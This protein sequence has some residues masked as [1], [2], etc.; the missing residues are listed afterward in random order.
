MGDGVLCF[1]GWPQAHEDEAER[2]VRA[3]LAIMQAMASMKA[4]DGEAL[5][6]RAGIATG[7][8]V[9]GDL[10]GEGAAQEE[11]VVGEAPNLAA[12]LQALAGPGQIVLSGATRRLLGDLFDLTDLGS[13]DLKGIAG[14]VEA[15]AVVGERAL[16]SRFE[17]R[18]PTLLSPLVGRDQEL[19]LILERWRQA[20]AGEGQVVLLSG[21]AG[22]GKSRIAQ[23]V[24]DTLDAE[25]HV[26]L[27]YQCSPYH[28]DSALYPTIQQ[29]TR[30]AGILHDDGPDTRLDKLE[31]LLSQGSED[32]RGVTPFIAALLGIEYE[33][34]YGEL[35]LGPQQQRSRTL[36]ILVDQLIG[37]AGK[38]PVLFC[39]EDLH[40]VDPTTLEL[41]ELA[42]D[43]MVEAPVLLLMTARPTFDH[44]VGGHPIVTRLALNRLG[45]SQIVAIAERITGGK[46]LPIDLLEEIAS[47]T[48]GVPLFVEE[49]TKTVLES[50]Q[51]RETETAFELDAP[52]ERL[53]IP[54]TLHD[55]LMARL[56][57]LQ[58]VKE[59]AQIAACIG[60]EFG[61]GL[62]EAA[63][64]LS[65][66]K[67]QEA[68]DRLIAAELIF[69]RGRPPEAFYIF[70]HALVRDAA[71][72]SLLKSK[73][74]TIH[75]RLLKVLEEEHVGEA[76]PEV[77]AQHAAEAGLDEK[78][79]DLWET[80]GQA[81]VA[82]PAYR[83]A[84]NHFSLAIARIGDQVESRHWQERE[85][86]LQVKLGQAL[87]AC[88]G[89]QAA[90][91]EQAFERA[92]IL[93]EALG[94][95]ALRFPA[96]YGQW[97]VSVLR[98]STSGY[99]KKAKDFYRLASAQEDPAPKIVAHRLL[100]VSRLM[101]GQLAEAR[102][103]FE[104]GLTYHCPGQ[105]HALAQSF[106]Q[107]PET[108]I[109][110]GLGWSLRLLGYPDQADHQAA[111][112]VR[113]AAALGHMN[114]LIYAHSWATFVALAIGD[115]RPALESFQATK[116]LT[117]Q[118]DLR[119][120]QMIS[121]TVDGIRRMDEG[122]VASDRPLLTSMAAYRATGS[123]FIVPMILAARARALLK[124]GK[125]E[126]VAE[127]L[128]EAKSMM[129]I[130]EE[131]WI[132][133][134]VHR[135]DGDYH[136]AMKDE[137]AAEERFRRALEVARSQEASTFELRAAVSL[138]R[139]WADQGERQKAHDLLAPIY[140]WFT[141]GLGTQG[142]RE[143]KQLLDELI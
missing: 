26:R 68:L 5:L 135:I 6:A 60:R 69:R 77:L 71:Y 106:G 79:I 47:K 101:R 118:H 72:E 29:L 9:V 55:S 111:L 48:D 35:G 8:V 17:A 122:D 12:R 99:L 113:H 143:A 129:D 75:A 33:G 78:A 108:A 22:I 37:L 85:L 117:N 86:D 43:N 131:F 44:G 107:D 98:D 119:L 3:G 10:V 14:P 56:D 66:G 90:E 67:L 126:G 94:N 51:L 140:G 7:L 24:I 21:E 128:A 49:L 110:A 91:T 63:S 96:L 42:L 23:G 138:A 52:L 16:E 15:F 103:Q 89:Y 54:S 104:T 124:F 30:A 115:S 116:L 139:L 73:R 2:A 46:S 34:R 142:L 141:E 4:P 36:Q 120:W 121:G 114:T 41:I 88:V 45:Q 123:R 83:E 62:L 112:A 132:E 100:G 95:T 13:Q 65:P 50:G 81:A 19:A 61:H 32:A 109:R 125:L 82:R 58:P 18:S 76:L 27:S 57:R 38:K 59:V 92:T 1:F 39:I 70:K 127:Q 93:T 40:W 84:I 74:Q 64:P 136:W 105:E 97:G 20:K 130:S 31:I 87:I 133:A 80:A 53:A 25:P 137:A 134:E 102:R 28:S 11:A